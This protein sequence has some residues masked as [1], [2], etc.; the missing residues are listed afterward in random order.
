MRLLPLWAAGFECGQPLRYLRLAARG[1]HL[2]QAF[3]LRL[4]DRGIDAECPRA[5]RFSLT[6]AIYSHHGPLAR[7]HGALVLVSCGLDFILNEAGLDGAQRSAQLVD[8]LQ[9]RERL[10]ARSSR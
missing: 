10:P 4:L 9:V 5:E 7:L 8:A 2:P 3:D 1:A 6:E